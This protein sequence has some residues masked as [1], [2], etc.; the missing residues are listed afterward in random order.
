MDGVLDFLPEYPE[1]N[2]SLSKKLFSK[3]EF[4]ELS[5]GPEEEISDVPG[6]LLLSQKLISRFMSPNTPYTSN[7]IVHGTGTG[8]T[9]V[10][11]AV[12]ESFKTLNATG[13]QRKPAIFLV[14]NEVIARKHYA[15]IANKC[16]KDEYS[17]VLTEREERQKL[18]RQ[19]ESERLA[20]MNKILTKSVIFRRLKKKVA[21]VYKIQTYRKFLT[22]AHDKSKEELR[23]LYSGR[24]I[25]IDE[26]HYFRNPDTMDPNDTAGKESFSEAEGLYPDLHRLL[27]SVDFFRILL[28]SATP[29]WD[30]PVEII[31]IMNLI[32]PDS[33]QLS[34][35]NFEATYFVDKKLTAEGKSL[36]RKAFTGRVSYLRPL[37]SDAKR[38][39]MGSPGQFL[40]YI[41]IVQSNMAGFQ[42]KRVRLAVKS[43]ESTLKYNSRDANILTFDND[44]EGP[45]FGKEAFKK[46][47]TW[48]EKNKKYRLVNKKL[49]DALTE[50]ETVEDKLEVLNQYSAVLAKTFSLILESPEE[51][52]FVINTIISGAGGVVT[53]GVLLEYFG[54]SVL[55]PYTKEIKHIS[56]RQRV[57]VV[58]S[59]E[60]TFSDDAKISELLDVFNDVSNAKGERI[61]IIVGSR[62]MYE[63]IDLKCVRQVHVLTPHWNLSVLDQAIGR[64]FRVGA[65]D[66]L[67]ED[68]RY[69][70]IY[71]HVGV[72][73]NSTKKTPIIRVYKIAEDKDILNTQIIREIK[74]A[75]FDCPLTYNRNVLSTDVDGS[76]ECDY[77]Q[78]KYTCLGWREEEMASRVV[79][80]TEDCDDTVSGSG[81]NMLYSSE[82]T[83]KFVPYIKEYL[84]TY[85][86]LTI[87]MLIDLLEN[88]KGVPDDDSFTDQDIELENTESD[89]PKQKLS[90]CRDDI[91][92]LLLTLESIISSRILLPNR[93]GVLGYLTED[94]NLYFLTPNPAGVSYDQWWYATNVVLEYTSELSNDVE[95]EQYRF[96]KDT[97][98]ELCK[99]DVTAFDRLHDRTKVL[100]FEYAYT[101]QY[102][103]KRLHPVVDQILAKFRVKLVPI[104]STDGHNLYSTEYTGVGYNIVLK[105]VKADG[106]IRI[107]DDSL[108]Q[109]RYADDEEQAAFVAGYKAKKKEMLSQEWTAEAKKR[110]IRA[111]RD[112][113][114][115]KIDR[116]IPGK[117]KAETK[118]RGM[119]CGSFTKL[120]MVKIM[121]KLG[122]FPSFAPDKEKLVTESI[123][124]LRE[125]LSERLSQPDPNIKHGV[126]LGEDIS[127][128]DLIRMQLILDDNQIKK[129]MVC[130]KLEEY[131]KREGLFFE[132]QS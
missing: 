93:I 113:Q 8:K 91:P 66:F 59:K 108:L 130:K 24:V 17:G 56:K 103:R 129:P 18:K 82:A 42:A 75:S 120:A 65:F 35:K 81:Y 97:V 14:P 55:S 16:T 11:S 87:Q 26:V 5:L 34:S 44:S 123:E 104:G 107:F 2:R 48:D 126:D 21:K 15:L 94:G 96:D 106:R 70:K 20:F 76:R 112:P 19:T 73:P 63:G 12:V 22:N 68:E 50:E 85:D 7:L 30:R 29:I 23:K 98:I 118:S 4:R 101:M 46:N 33:E 121:V 6:E 57:A 116:W 117:T 111:F 3:K 84:R 125:Y 100:I 62:K 78:C 95:L 92:T 71:R 80:N 90:F 25:V 124:D 32:L 89:K 131:F 99:G 105:D 61:R 110:G 119:V 109:W 72:F 38:E 60:G 45:V 13:E 10:A 28:L 77:Q 9:C 102:K 115:F 86:V 52:V 122:Y 1:V 128:D 37:M 47:I 88:E 36:L 74:R 53:V 49:H 51:K 79:G 69:V 127:R 64:V 58:S 114:G 41:P 39:N 40:K 31:D 27:H 83:K 67:P 54:L 43:D 132:T